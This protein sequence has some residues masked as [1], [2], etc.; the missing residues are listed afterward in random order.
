MASNPNADL[1]GLQSP[2]GPS[3]PPPVPTVLSPREAAFYRR[4][5]Q[6]DHLDFLNAFFKRKVWRDIIDDL[7]E[8]FRDMSLD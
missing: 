6:L 3:V 2:S 7:S 5:K 8:R 4:L 1:T